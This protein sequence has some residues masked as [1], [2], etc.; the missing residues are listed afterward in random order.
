VFGEGFTG[1]WFLGAGLLVVGVVV[2]GRRE[3]GEKPGGTVG[4]EVG[5]G[6]AEYKDEDGER[7]GLLG[8]EDVL[9][10]EGEEV[11]VEVEGGGGR[12]KEEDVDEPIK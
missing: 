9:E 7:A 2:I 4:V 6:S 8:D 12:K 5:R 3:E 1:L 11:E 10:W